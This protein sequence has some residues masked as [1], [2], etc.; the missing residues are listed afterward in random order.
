MMQQVRCIKGL[1][2]LFFNKVDIVLVPI[3][4]QLLPQRRDQ[5]GVQR[6]APP[7]LQQDQHR[8]LH[9]VQFGARLPPQLERWAQL[10]PRAALPPLRRKSTTKSSDVFI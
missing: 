2:L 4:A 6:A 5:L 3:G 1:L 10:A 9:R 8:T 7:F